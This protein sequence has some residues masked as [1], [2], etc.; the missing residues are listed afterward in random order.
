MCRDRIGSDD[1]R[2]THEYLAAMLGARRA[3]VTDA[4]RPLQEEGLV[5][6]HRG[7]IAI[8]DGAGLEARSCEC[9]FVVRDEYDRLFGNVSSPNPAAGHRRPRVELGP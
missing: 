7:R 5:K 8:L 4:L 6:S 1:I 3:S 2:L 9:Y